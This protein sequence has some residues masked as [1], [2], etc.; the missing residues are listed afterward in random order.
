MFV[1]MLNLLPMG[2]LDGG[3]ILYARLP[4]WHQRVALAFW[5]VVIALGSL[6]FGWYIWGGLVL[7]LSRGRLGHPPVLDT[8]RPLPRS[9]VLAWWVAVALFAATFAPAPLTLLG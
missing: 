5:L 8:W 6:W 4:R 2:Q 1:T 9:R 7:L 3:H